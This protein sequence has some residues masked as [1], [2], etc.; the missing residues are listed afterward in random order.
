MAS[1]Q[2]GSWNFA[3]PYYV[4]YKVQRK[5]T[6]NQALLQPLHENIFGQVDT[7]EHH[8]AGFGLARR[9]RGAQVAAHQLVHPLKDH[10][11]L[12]TLHIQN[13]LLT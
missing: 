1:K 2:V 7:N 13:A 11:A 12:G 9:P 4:F 5:P 6:S 3:T 10:F 8:L